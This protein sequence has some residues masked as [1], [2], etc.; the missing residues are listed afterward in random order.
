MKAEH[1]TRN[2]LSLLAY[3]RFHAKRMQEIKQRQDE[4]ARELED[5]LQAYA[6]G[7]DLILWKLSR[8]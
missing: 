5:V 1:L 4:Y 6:R 8:E 2:D 7:E 3:V